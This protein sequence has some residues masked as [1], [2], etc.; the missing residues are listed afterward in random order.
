MRTVEDEAGR[1]YLLLKRSGESSLVRDAATGEARFL[2]NDDLV[3]LDGV[4]PLTAAAEAVSPHLRRLLRTVHDDRGLGL[5]VLLAHEPRSARAL[6]GATDLC[7]SDLL[8]MAT[9]LRAAG[10]IAETTVDGERGYAVTEDGREAIEQLQSGGS[11]GQSAETS[12][13]ESPE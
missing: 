6:L 2:P 8:G 12:S 5:L 7:E 10:L 4:D 11:G 1:R 13:A 3:T 9:E